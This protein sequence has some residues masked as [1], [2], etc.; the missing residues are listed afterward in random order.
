MQI[1]FQQCFGDVNHLKLCFVLSSVNENVAI[2]LI[3]IV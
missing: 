2:P 3:I 1:Y